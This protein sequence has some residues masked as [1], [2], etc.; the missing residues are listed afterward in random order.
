MLTAAVNAAWEYNDVQDEMGRNAPQHQATVMSSRQDSF[1]KLAR[2]PNGKTSVSFKVLGRIIDGDSDAYIPALQSA[3]IFI[4][5]DD[6]PIQR[7]DLDMLTNLGLEKGFITEKQ[8]PRFVKALRGAKT[9]RMEVPI[10]GIGQMVYT[11]DVDGLI[12]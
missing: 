1:L 2:Q 9:L 4:R 8:R 7:Y 12:W 6:H 5:F 3:A 10:Y 11:L